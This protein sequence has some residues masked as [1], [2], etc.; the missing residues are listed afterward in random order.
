MLADVLPGMA[1]RTRSTSVLMSV[2]YTSLSRM[3]GGKH[4][5]VGIHE[6][7]PPKRVGLN[8]D[9]AAPGDGGWRG[10][11]QVLNF[12]YH[13]HLLAHRDDVTILQGRVSCCRPAPYSCSRSKLRRQGRPTP[14]YLRSGMVS[15]AAVRNCF[16]RTPS[17]H[18]PLW[19]HFAVE[20]PHRNGLGIDG[21]EARFLLELLLVHDSEGP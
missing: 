12:K 16:A 10:L 18:S 20:L 15:L 6:A 5:V 7:L 1:P 11:C 19:S 13:V 4:A 17:F 9:H 2:R 3:Y 8:V 21:N 14:T